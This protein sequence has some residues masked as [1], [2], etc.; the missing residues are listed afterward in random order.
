MIL[1]KFLA[2]HSVYAKGEEA[3]FQKGVADRFIRGHIAEFVKDLDEDKKEKKVVTPRE[4]KR[5]YVT[6]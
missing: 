2:R 6:K 5:D 3:A 4:T 1:V